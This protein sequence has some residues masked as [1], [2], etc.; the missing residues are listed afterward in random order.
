[1]ELS[2]EDDVETH[3]YLQA[4]E[5]LTSAQ[6]EELRKMATRLLPEYDFLVLVLGQLNY[7]DVANALDFTLFDRRVEDLY[8]RIERQDSHRQRLEQKTITH[9][10]L[11]AYLST[12]APLY[13]DTARIE[14]EGLQ[15]RFP[16]D[17]PKLRTLFERYTILFE[18]RRHNDVTQGST[19][20]NQTVVAPLLRTI[21]EAIRPQ[22]L[23]EGIFVMFVLDFVWTRHT[24]QEE[25][26]IRGYFAGIATTD[27]SSPYR[28]LPEDE[29]PALEAIVGPYQ[30]KNIKSRS[31]NLNRVIQTNGLFPSLTTDSVQRYTAY[32][33]EKSSDDDEEGDDNYSDTQ[34]ED[35]FQAETLRREYYDQIPRFYEMATRTFPNYGKRLARLK[36]IELGLRFYYPDNARRQRVWNGLLRLW[37]RES[38]PPLD[39][40]E[41]VSP[42]T[43]DVMYEA[44]IGATRDVNAIKN[45]MTTIGGARSLNTFVIRV[46]ED[47]SSAL[48]ATV[49]GTTDL[50]H[51]LISLNLSGLLWLLH[52]QQLLPANVPHLTKLTLSRLPLEIQELEDVRNALGKG[53]FQ[54]GEEQLAVWEQRQE[55]L[56]DV[57]NELKQQQSKSDEDRL[58]V[59]IQ[60]SPE[61]LESALARAGLDQIRLN[62]NV[63]AAIARA[64]AE[65]VRWCD[66]LPEDQVHARDLVRTT[67]TSVRVAFATLVAIEAANV[68]LRVPRNYNKDLQFPLTRLDKE[69]ALNNLR[70]FVPA[71][72]DHEGRMRFQ[73]PT[74]RGPRIIHAYR[75]PRRT[76]P[77]GAWNPALPA[78]ANRYY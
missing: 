30:S 40:L 24:P 47:Q 29:S 44:I 16:V 12:S 65:A 48:Y 70:R 64:H 33:K 3:D 1:M 13:R 56:R 52:K 39:S 71:G 77:R 46:D 32:A 19:V 50:Y 17:D 27:E 75:E 54:F 51:Y 11:R 38:V 28:P 5:P 23:W 72:R 58:I 36:R 43:L 6:R 8:E 22:T 55:M 78:R 7:K 31:A 14:V 59:A 42:D 63:E 62:A 57:D 35:V 67:T 73:L 20:Y 69:S 74:T 66:N 76:P 2:N 9:S 68:N 18:N 26:G 49:R 15:A 10:A 37:G 25:I 45:T 41:D 21:P 60:N 4:Y 34:L 61:S 53:I